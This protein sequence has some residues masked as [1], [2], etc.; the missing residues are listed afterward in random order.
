MAG[1]FEI[2]KNGTQ[3]IDT[4]LTKFLLIKFLVTFILITDIV[5]NSNSFL[6]PAPCRRFLV[7]IQFFFFP[8]GRGAPGTGT[9]DL[10]FFSLSIFFCARKDFISVMGT[11]FTL[12]LNLQAL[13]LESCM[14]I[15]WFLSGVLLTW[16]FWQLE[17]ITFVSAKDSDSG[18][19]NLVVPIFSSG[20]VHFPRNCCSGPGCLGILIPIGSSSTVGGLYGSVYFL[21]P[22]F[23][24][25]VLLTWLFWQFE[26]ITFFSAKDSDSGLLNLLVLIFSS[27][28]VHFFR[29]AAVFLTGLSTVHF[30]WLELFLAAE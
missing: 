1:I 2:D 17:A 14:W 3:V 22:R 5:L 23:L 8:L 13:S 11:P 12:T 28:S 6:I 18:L 25:G 27:G 4:I 24:T 20:S 10:N 29:L 16:L 26:T 7:T 30:S 15:P 9:L 21:I 19:L